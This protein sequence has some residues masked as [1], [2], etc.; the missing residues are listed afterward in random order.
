M[1]AE[2]STV[3]LAEDAVQRILKTDH[4]SNQ[5]GNRRRAVIR[6]MKDLRKALEAKGYSAE[7][8]DNVRKDVLDLV[9]LARNSEGE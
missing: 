2:M 7:E 9:K 1:N 3:Q 6:V 5:F 4:M 8:I